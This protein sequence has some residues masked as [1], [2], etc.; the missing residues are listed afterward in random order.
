MFSFGGIC[1]SE[2]KFIWIYMHTYVYKIKYI[3]IHFITFTRLPKSCHPHCSYVTL[4][5]YV[6]NF[7]TPHRWCDPPKT[8]GKWKIKYFQKPNSDIKV[9][10]VGGGV[11]VGVWHKCVCLWM[12]PFTFVSVTLMHQNT[13]LHTHIH[14]QFN[15][16]GFAFLDVFIYMHI[17]HTNICTYVYDVCTNKHLYVYVTTICFITSII[18][19]VAGVV[20]DVVAVFVHIAFLTGNIYTVFKD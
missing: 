9:N 5:L 15:E 18:D 13:Y 10:F 8:N 6:H 2:N 11:V 14:T 20:V 1:R 12:F 19:V 7:T 3:E 17:M 4:H 16:N